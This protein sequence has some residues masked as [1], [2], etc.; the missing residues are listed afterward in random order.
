MSVVTFLSDADR[1]RSIRAEGRV[2]LRFG[3]EGGRTALRQLGEGG[4]YRVKFPDSTEMMQAVIV[5][6]GG[7]MTGGDHLTIDVICEEGSAA[8]I[9]TPAAEKIYRA[10]DDPARVEVVIRVAAGATCHWM[11]QETILFDSAGLKRSLDVRLE[12]GARFLLAESVL[13]GR[14]AMGEVL[15]AGLFRDRWR[16]AREGRLIYA[17]DVRLEGAITEHL[18]QKATG[19]GA[20]A[21]ATAILVSDEAEALLDA[22]RE[23]FATC[24]CEVAA[25]AMKGLLI[26]RF[27]GKES[28]PLRADFMHYL[29]WL[30]GKPLSGLW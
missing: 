28:G 29:Q 15:K 21:M 19:D 2:V 26:A 18:A 1:L 27:L 9:S 16:I 25:T 3:E 22:A 12:K 5:N 6:T 20:R 24:R 17:E 8:A 23:T 4:G 13:F 30:R 7:G 11:P 14:E 10:I